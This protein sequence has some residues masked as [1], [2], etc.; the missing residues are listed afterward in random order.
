MGGHLTKHGRPW[1]TIVDHG[2]P[3]SFDHH[4]HLGY[5]HLEFKVSL[6]FNIS[7]T[8]GRDADCVY[9]GKTYSLLIVLFAK[10]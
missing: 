10:F 7:K 6:S 4:L 5:F 2:I 1:T 9:T 3:W 8:D